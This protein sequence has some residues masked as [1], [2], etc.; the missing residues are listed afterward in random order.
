MYSVVLM[1]AMAGGGEVI[2]FSHHGGCYGGVVY[3]SCHGSSGCY[4]GVVHHCRHH[5]H[6]HHHTHHSC[7]GC[8]GGCCGSVHHH[9]HSCHGCYGGCC[10]SVIYYSCCGGCCGGVIIKPKDGDKKKDG[11]GKD[12]KDGKDKEEEISEAPAKLVVTLPADA[13]LKI[14]GQTTKSTGAERTFVTPKLS[15]SEQYSWT[16][17]AEVVKDGKAV[18][19]SQKVAMTPGKTARVTL[20]PPTGVASR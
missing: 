6:H 15:A 20:T 14:E 16:L 2:D 10:G 13:K 9:H 1:V 11:K 8:Y 19:W 4:G 18:T 17:Q 3:H 5:H 7:H 12:G